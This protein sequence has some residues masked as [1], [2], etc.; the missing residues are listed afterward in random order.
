MN[1]TLNWTKCHGD[2]WC[3]L[4]AVNLEHAHFNNI[5][6][7]YIIW[8]GGTNP[9]VVYVGQGAIRE[10]IRKHRNEPNVQQYSPSDM[11]VTWAKVEPRFRDGV[12]AYFASLWRPKEGAKHP[13][14]TH[15]EANSPW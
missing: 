7:V 9:H 11:F 2:V 8:H 1:L 5:E 6:G 14:A 13:N 4:N 10:R 3:K 12:E 15:V